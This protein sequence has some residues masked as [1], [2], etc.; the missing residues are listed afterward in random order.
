ML[1]TCQPKRNVSCVTNCLSPLLER[2]RP[3]RF[4]WKKITMH[5]LREFDGLQSDY[6]LD[7]IIIRLDI[8][9]H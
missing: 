5:S 7:P 4:W 6:R 3:D 9:P 2:I 8:P 1:V